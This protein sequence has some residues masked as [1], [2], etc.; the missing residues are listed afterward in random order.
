MSVKFKVVFASD[1][2]DDAMDCIEQRLPE[3]EGST[4]T[5]NPDS[6]L[7]VRNLNGRAIH[8]AARSWLA[9]IDE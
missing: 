9:V 6:T 1:V 3:F 4:Y 5:I 2:D 8:F 7:T